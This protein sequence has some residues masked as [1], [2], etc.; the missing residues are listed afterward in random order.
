[1]DI[2]QNFNDD[3]DFKYKL[4]F[5]V[6]IPDEKVSHIQERNFIIF[7]LG[8]LKSFDWLSYTAKDNQGAVFNYCAVFVSEFAKKNLTH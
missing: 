7:Q 5:T 1:M 2:V 8:W 3:Q 4:L 6:W